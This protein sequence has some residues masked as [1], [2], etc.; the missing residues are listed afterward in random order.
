MTGGPIDFYLL[1]LIIAPLIVRL[2]SSFR[3]AL[4]FILYEAGFVLA[5]VLLAFLFLSSAPVFLSLAFFQNVEGNGWLYDV[6][7]KTYN[8]IVTIAVIVL[9]SFFAQ[10]KAFLAGAALTLLWSAGAA[11]WGALSIGRARP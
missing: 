5:L 1:C 9:M 7:V 11:A 2:R 10:V 4:T 6:I 3:N 8:A